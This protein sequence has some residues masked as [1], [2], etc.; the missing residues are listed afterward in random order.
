MAVALGGRDGA[1]ELVLLL[2]PPLLSTAAPNAFILNILIHHIIRELHLKIM[3]M[4]L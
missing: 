3:L 2:L 1:G 4:M